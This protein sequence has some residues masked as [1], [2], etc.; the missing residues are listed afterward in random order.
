MTCSASTGSGD[1]REK[2]TVQREARTPDGAGGHALAWVDVATVR[3]RVKPGGGREQLQAQQTQA[4]TVC[5]VTIRYRADVITG[6]RLLWGGKTLN[7]RSATNPD[8]RRQWLEMLC[9]E[10][11]AT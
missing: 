9:D 1:L 6:M 10:G 8:E 2:V 4:V 11:V 7:I 5:T 3:A